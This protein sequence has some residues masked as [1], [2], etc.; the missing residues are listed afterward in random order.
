M[1]N[2]RVGVSPIPAHRP[3]QSLSME[4]FASNWPV[5][6]VVLGLVLVGMWLIRRLVKLAFIG[7]AI[8]AV[9]LFVWPILAT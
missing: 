1:S 7:V 3:L 5:I 8:G 2:D 4:T 9:A 6:L